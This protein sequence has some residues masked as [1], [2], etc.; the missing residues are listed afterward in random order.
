MTRILLW[1][2]DLMTRV[3]MESAWKAAGAQM[4]K[5]TDSESP[6]LVVVDLTARDA[7]LHIQRLRAAHPEGAIVAFGPHVEGEA[8][9]AARDAG[10]DTLLTRGNALAGVLKRL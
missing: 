10:A 4:L 8:F 5:K 1:T 7:L 3:R 9:K 6:D 2:D